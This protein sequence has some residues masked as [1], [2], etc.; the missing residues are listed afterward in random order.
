MNIFGIGFGEVLLI[1]VIGLIILGPGKLVELAK[2]LGRLSRNIKIMSSD[3]TNIV[4]KE[5]DLQEKEPENT[6]HKPDEITNDTSTTNLPENTKNT[7]KSSN[8]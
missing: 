7:D 3:F 6:H 2:S 8:K 4:N 5:M 1:L